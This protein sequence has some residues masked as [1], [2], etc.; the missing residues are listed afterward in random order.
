MY[1]ITM[2]IIKNNTDYARTTL[3]PY[4]Y[5]NHPAAITKLLGQLGMT[6]TVG[7]N[8]MIYTSWYTKRL[9]SRHNQSDVSHYV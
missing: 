6:Y 5:P 4:D 1:E 9:H 2:Y 7:Q 3:P 8:N